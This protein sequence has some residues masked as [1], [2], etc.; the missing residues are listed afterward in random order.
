MGTFLAYLNIELKRALKSLPYLLAG[1]AALA[2]FAGAAAF[3]AGKL[4]YAGEAVGRIRVGVAVPS[5]DQTSKWLMSM[6]SSLESV[7]SLCEFE[8]VEEEEGRKQLRQGEIYALMLLPDGLVQG[9]VDGSNEPVTV[10]FP[11]SAGLEAAVFRELTDAGAGILR[12]AQAAIY[13]ADELLYESGKEELVPEA[14][15]E[16]NSTY[17]K[18]ALSRSVYFKPEKVSAAGDIGMGTYYGISAAAAVLLLLGIPA[19]GYIRPLSPVMEGKLALIGMG[20]PLR[21]AARTLCLG[22]LFAAV[23]AAPWA[24][25]LSLGLL[26]AEA[27]S[28]PVW[29]LACTA[30]AGWVILV[31]ELCRST[32]AGICVLFITTAVMVFM[33]GGIVPSVFLPQ[34]V[35]AA[36]RF[37]P[38]AVLMDALR[39]MVSGEG[40]AWPADFSAGAAPF[41]AGGCLIQVIR[42][43]GMEVLFF[44]VSAAGGRRERG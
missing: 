11:E 25:C 34:A 40:A 21:L 27:L 10:L 30:A 41:L 3:S 16:L 31:Y 18:Y 17:M 24:L 2:L 42:L 38:A 43:T 29:L 14:E 20:R 5:S 37:T 36:G 28:A 35:Q 33:A 32:L 1:A 26:E 19:A 39:W 7:S 8:Y 13:A 15:R 23:T 6:V 9:I 22:F 44:A 4:L 12:T